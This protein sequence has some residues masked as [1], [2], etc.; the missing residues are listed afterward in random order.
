MN[1]MGR[2]NSVYFLAKM[3]MVVNDEV[4]FIR[5][6]YD[7][8][9]SIEEIRYLL[10]LAEAINQVAARLRELYDYYNQERQHSQ[11]GSGEEENNVVE[12]LTK[13]S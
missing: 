7:K 9:M 4:R 11:Q 13:L 6:T 8:E 10:R 3:V 2:L 1:L 12:I 5:Q